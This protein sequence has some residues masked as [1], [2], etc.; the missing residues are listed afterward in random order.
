LRERN[1][2]VDVGD[3]AECSEAASVDLSA[4]RRASGY[5]RRVP[6]LVVIVANVVVALC[7]FLLRRVEPDWRARTLLLVAL[8]LASVALLVVFVFGED[9]YRGNGISRWDAYPSPDGALEPLFFATVALMTLAAG[10]M[11]LAVVQHRSRLLRASTL[12]AA[13]GALLLGI[14][15]VIGFSTN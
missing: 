15:T 13:V 3:D 4:E 7:L 2:A 12:V 8:P 9:S 14:P 5:A 1:A 10:F 6:P 11:M